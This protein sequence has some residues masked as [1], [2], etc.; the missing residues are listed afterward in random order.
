MRWVFGLVN[1][2]SVWPYSINRPRYMKAVLSETRAA[3]GFQVAGDAGGSGVVRQGR[4][5]RHGLTK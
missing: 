1:T 3:Y 5:H 2:V 4:I